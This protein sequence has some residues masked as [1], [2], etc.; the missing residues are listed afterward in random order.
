LRPREKARAGP[1]PIEERL[2][3][4]DWLILFIVA[5]SVLLAL[6][7]GFIVEMFSLGGA[8][9]G[10]VG[11]AWGY[12]LLTPLFQRFVNL[13]PLAQLLSFLTIFVV[14]FAGMGVTGRMLSRAA[15]ET[16]MRWADRLMGAAFGLVRGIAIAAVLVLAFATFY[17]DSRTVSG[18]ALGRQLLGVARVASWLAPAELR[19]RFHLGAAQM[20][21]GGQS[22]KAGGNTGK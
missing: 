17:P 19:E 10:L 16:G 5:A 22:P 6:S 18:S 3:A 11:A 2:T 9:V 1:A 15:K 7:Q 4:L 8:V 20:R 14:L 13:T 21:G 12:P